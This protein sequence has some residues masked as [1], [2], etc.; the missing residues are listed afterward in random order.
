MFLCEECCQIITELNY[1][2]CRQTKFLMAM[3]SFVQLTCFSNMFLNRCQPTFIGVFPS[4][5]IF[6]RILTSSAGFIN[7]YFKSEP[8]K[9]EHN[10]QVRSKMNNNIFFLWTWSK[11]WKWIFYLILK[12]KFWFDLIFDHKFFYFYLTSNLEIFVTCIMILEMV[13]TR[14]K[15]TSILLLLIENLTS[16]PRILY[17][18]TYF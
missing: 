14:I 5:L 17:S 11:S 13:L 10:G 3:T 12:I 1:F 18:L 15:K 8:E 6:R 4:Y 16:S 9:L 7:Y 2:L